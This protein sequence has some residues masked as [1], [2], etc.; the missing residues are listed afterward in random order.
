MR[1]NRLT[2]LLLALLLILAGCKPTGEEGPSQAPSEPA[3]PTPSVSAEPS[4]WIED[5]ELFWTTLDEN[6]PF[7]DVMRRTTG[8]TLADI[9][10]EFR[11]AAEQVQ[12]AEELLAVLLDASKEF[13]KT[14]HLGIHEAEWYNHWCDLF[15][16]TEEEY[17]PLSTH[18]GQRLDNEKSRALYGRTDGAD[19]ARSETAAEPEEPNLTFA[20]YPEQ[21]AAYVEVREMNPDG[22]D[23]EAEE[24]KLVDF[25]RSIEAE[26][27]EH[28]IIDIRRNPGGSSYY[29]QILAGPI[30]TSSCHQ[31]HYALIN[32]GDEVQGYYDAIGIRRGEVWTLDY[33]PLD[34]L[35]A[36]EPGDLE[37]ATHFWKVTTLVGAKFQQPAFTGRVW[38]LVGPNNYSASE[39]FAVFCKD[40][41]FATLVGQRTGGDGIGITPLCCVLPN[42]GVV[43]QFATMNGLNL[44]GGS[45]EELGTVPDIEVP[46]GEDAL[47]ACLRAI[48]EAGA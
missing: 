9:E 10:A 17:G 34:E 36:L 46:E 7:G 27:Y 1:R 15:C 16:G 35:P 26:G 12:S 6:Y 28:C 37:W 2:A 11:P 5:W 39:W 38:L 29:T 31:Q 21:K 48:E 22:G 44:D 45:N 42:S 4:P 20:Y 40:F 8:R 43:Y 33:L 18:F 24:Q 41:G 23:W 19:A 30:L 25:Y 14:G 32:N 3:D 47:E 13:G